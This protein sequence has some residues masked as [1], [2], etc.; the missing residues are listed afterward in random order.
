M[1]LERVIIRSVGSYECV[2]KL[3]LPTSEERISGRHA[4]DS[5]PPFIRRPKQYLEA[6]RTVGL[7]KI[8][9]ILNHKESENKSLNILLH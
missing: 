5:L 3:G 7:V 6:E 8:F 9:L 1:S 2:Y 4:L